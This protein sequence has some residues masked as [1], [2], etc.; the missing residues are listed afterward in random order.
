MDSADPK[1]VHQALGAQ[2][3]LLGHHAQDLKGIMGMLEALSSIVALL[4]QRLE[5][6]FSSQFPPPPVG[7]PPA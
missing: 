4:S 2:G 6:G 3:A 1:S 7:G 5:Q